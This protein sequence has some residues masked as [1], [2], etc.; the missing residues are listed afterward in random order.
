MEIPPITITVVEPGSG[1]PKPE[2]LSVTVACEGTGCVLTGTK[3]VNTEA[4]QATF[5]GL[6]ITD[7]AASVKLVFTA[8]GAE[9]TG[10]GTFQVEAAGGSRE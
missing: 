6:A 7:P 5:S 10:T 8:P 2:A 4:G 3:T 9:S 1:T